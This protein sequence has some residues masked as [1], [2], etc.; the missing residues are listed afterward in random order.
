MKFLNLLIFNNSHTRMLATITMMV[1][2]LFLSIL[3]GVLA[4]YSNVILL[5]PLLALYGL[6]FIL[7]APVSWIIWIIFWAAFVVTGPSAYF[8][9]FTQL[10]WLTVLMGAAL[11]LPVL[12]HLLRSKNHIQ[13]IPVSNDLFLPV[14]FLLLVIFSTVIDHPQFADFVNA[15]RHYL[16]MWPLMLVFMFGLVRPEMLMQLW[17]AL[18]PLAILQLPMAL[19]QYFFVVKKSTRLSPWDAVVGTFPGDISGSGDSAG[20]AIMLLI[21]IMV[22]IALW[23]GSKLHGVWVILVVLAALV[24]LTLA[25]VKA[26]IMLLPVMIVLYY[27]RELLQRPVESIAIVV[28]A[29]MVV[30]GLFLMY[31][32]LHYND[33][34][35]LIYN[36]SNQPSSTYEYV[37]RALS[38][39]N[40]SKDLGQLGRT[41]HLVKWWEINVKSGD[42]Q[43]SL[44]GYGMGATAD[45]RIGVGELVNRFPYQINISSSVVLLWE[46]GILGHLIFL[47]ILLSGA[48]TSGRIAKNECIPETH[49]ILLRVGEVGLFLLI[50]TLPYKNIHFYSN[51]IQFLMML[52][53]GQAAYWSRFVSNNSKSKL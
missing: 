46:T 39:D 28:A 37:V 32:K 23:R 35:A 34:P 16:F 49:R 8:I 42:L 38:P 14:I 12:L 24:T 52:M 2:V 19:Y 30:G 48:W 7:A 44:F 25:E 51:P 9:R 43:H 10:Q 6:F 53:L 50:M 27:R 22:A 18:M 33:R 11:L 15:S 36:N 20:M 21:A 40:E 1:G 26:P 29:F 4:A 31:E 5:V 47:L 17:K 3:S 41:T 45:T 13:S